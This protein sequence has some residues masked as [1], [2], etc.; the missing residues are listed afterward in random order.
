MYVYLDIQCLHFWVLWQQRML[1][2]SVLKILSTTQEKLITSILN[3]Q[4]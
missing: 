2:V 3:I 4:I 1:R